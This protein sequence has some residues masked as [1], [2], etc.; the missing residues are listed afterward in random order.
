MIVAVLPVF[1]WKTCNRIRTRIRN[2]VTHSLTGIFEM[3]FF[4]QVETPYCVIKISGKITSNDSKLLDDQCQHLLSDPQIQGIILNLKD[5]RFID[6]T[7]MA[8]IVFIY[9]QVMAFQKKI[10]VCELDDRCSDLFEITGADQF[11]PL[12]RTESEAVQFM[13]TSS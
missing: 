1:L 13:S 2:R 4:C 6:S 12:F 7:G 9:N 10:A 3:Q 11:L 5:T 8:T